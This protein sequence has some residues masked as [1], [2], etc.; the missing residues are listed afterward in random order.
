MQTK[1][2]SSLERTRISPRLHLQKGYSHGAKADKAPLTR[3]AHTRTYT[4]FGA[5]CWLS[6]IGQ[7]GK[8]SI[9][10]E[11]PLTPNAGGDQES[12]LGL[13]KS[14][15]AMKSSINMSAY[16]YRIHAQIC[17]SFPIVAATGAVL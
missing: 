8:E 13:E 11:A 7:S 10:N 2:D 1:I 15:R 6:V 17:Y 3:R 14:R 16:R 12:D 5:G 9:M 4:R